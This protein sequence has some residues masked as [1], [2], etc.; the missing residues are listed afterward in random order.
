[1]ISSDLY[2]ILS[3][4]V[5]EESIK[6]FSIEDTTVGIYII[7]DQRRNQTFSVAVLFGHSVVPFRRLTNHCQDNSFI[8]RCIQ[9]KSEIYIH[10]GWNH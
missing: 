6:A 4:G 5:D 7:K 10:L 2:H 1:V 9:L 3:L 8:Y